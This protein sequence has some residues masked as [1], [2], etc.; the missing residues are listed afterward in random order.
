MKIHI[1]PYFCMAV[2]LNLRSSDKMTAIYNSSP[3]RYS[4]AA[5]SSVD[6]ACPFFTAGRFKHAQLARMMLG[7]IECDDTD[8]ILTIIRAGWSG[9]IKAIDNGER[10]FEHL[11][12]AACINRPNGT[13]GLSALEITLIPAV[14]CIA[15]QAKDI[16]IEYNGVMFDGFVQWIIAREKE[17]NGFSRKRTPDYFKNRKTLIESDIFDLF[18]SPP[19]TDEIPELVPFYAAEITLGM[20][21]ELYTQGIELTRS[22]MDLINAYADDQ[23]TAALAARHY[24]LLKALRQDSNWYSKEAVRRQKKE[25]TESQREIQSL[26][27]KLKHAEEKAAFLSANN[28]LVTRKLV[29]AETQLAKQSA[30]QQELASLRNTLY[31]LSAPFEDKGGQKRR[32]LPDHI[33]SIGGPGTWINAMKA[34]LPSIR[35]LSADVSLQDDLIRKASEL[36]IYADYIGHSMYYRAVDLAKLNNVPI[37]YWPGSNLQRCLDAITKA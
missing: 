24:L 28:D 1:I 5:E 2:A 6:Y 35:F 8:N 11:C 33:V 29:S 19:D 4:S 30:D 13:L 22:D 23:V 31:S 17:R 37:N 25:L 18:D 27:E 7:I 36:W 16:H 20:D 21:L 10:D 9:L 14:V 3:D 32:E 26:Q 15:T 12:T 34:H